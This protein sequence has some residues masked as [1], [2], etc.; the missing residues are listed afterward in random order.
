MTE[1]SELLVQIAKISGQKIEATDQKIHNFQLTKIGKKR[2]VRMTTVD[3]ISIRGQ[4]N[5][6]DEAEI[7]PVEIKIERDKIKICLKNIKNTLSNL[8]LKCCSPLKGCFFQA[9]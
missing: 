9:Q 6:E 1:K 7:N 3:F 2:K 8:P 5:L 4:Q